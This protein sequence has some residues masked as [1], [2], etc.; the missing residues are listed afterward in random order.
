M[1][2]QPSADI[3]PAQK[4]ELQRIVALL[5]GDRLLAHSVG[6]PFDVHEMLLQGLPGKAL[7][8]L[9]DSVVVLRKPASLEKA[10]GISLRTL[11]RRKDAPM[12]PLSQEQSSRTWK[13][14]DVLARATSVLGSQDEA[15]QWLERPAIGLNQRRPIDL[16]AT[17]AGTEIV[18]DFL[19]RLEYGVYA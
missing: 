13:F 14:A 7:T 1:A 19:R 11:Q 15:E 8:H 2:T 6:N 9:V 4:L 10:V 3:Q 18:E 17:A 12:K 16:L 5:G